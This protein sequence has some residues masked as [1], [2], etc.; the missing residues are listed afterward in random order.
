MNEETRVSALLAENARL[1]EARDNWQRNAMDR[2]ADW[3]KC[4]IERDAALARA[5]AAESLVRECRPAVYSSH[6]A[7]YGTRL[8]LSHTLLARVDAALASAASK[9]NSDDN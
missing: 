3:R 6:M 4:E 7:Q 1:R 2:V 9:E 5:E 8:A